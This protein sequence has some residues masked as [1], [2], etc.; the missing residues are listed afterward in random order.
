MVA[1]G[2]DVRVWSGRIEAMRLLMRE[3]GRVGAGV[4]SIQFGWGRGRRS[5]QAD[6][7]KSRFDSYWLEHEGVRDHHW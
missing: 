7:Y 3:R 5:P 2:G 1:G 6:I 4:V